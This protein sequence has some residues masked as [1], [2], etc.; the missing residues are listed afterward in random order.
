MTHS[1]HGKLALEASGFDH[2]FTYLRCSWLNYVELPERMTNVRVRVDL[3][4]QLGPPHRPRPD[5]A[6]WQK[7]LVF[8]CAEGTFSL[9]AS[10]IG[11]SRLAEP[12]IESI[13]QVDLPL[14][15]G[16]PPLREL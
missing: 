10:L 9:H 14:W 1:G 8:E 11:T 4:A 3:N 5:F 12:D 15:K 6:R 16:G 13:A 7:R 2:G